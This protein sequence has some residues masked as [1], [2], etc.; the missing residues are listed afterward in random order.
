M[1]GICAVLNLSVMPNSLLPMDSSLPGVS[2]HGDS[3]GK[4]TEMGCHAL[5]QRIFLTQ[6]LNP[7]LPHCRQILCYLSHQGS[8]PSFFSTHL[9]VVEL[10]TIKSGSVIS[11]ALVLFCFCFFATV[12]HGFMAR[13]PLS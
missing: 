8:P 6:G 1:T 2:V 10:S 12:L 13:V 11:T 4:N 3:Q 9:V 7:G 5:L